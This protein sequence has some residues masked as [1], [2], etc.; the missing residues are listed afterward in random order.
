MKIFLLLSICLLFVFQSFAQR[1]AGTWQDYLSFANAQKVAIGNERV[2]CASLGGLFYYDLQDNSVYKVSQ[3]SD[4]GIKTIE[5]DPANNRLL[6]AY[7]NSNLDIISNGNVV[8]LSDIKRKMI[9]ADKSINDI[10]IRGD[11]AYLAC[12]FG[13][14]VVNLSKQEVKDTYFIGEDG[15]PL[16]VYD[17]EFYGSSIYA[18][19]ET[20]LLKAAEEGT[21]LLDYN[22]WTKVNDIP[23]ANARFS[24]LAVHQ[25]DLMANYA[26]GE[27]GSD[28]VFTFDG[29]SWN[30]YLTE[31]NSVI[32]MSSTQNYLSVTGSNKVLILDASHSV[33]GRIESYTLDDEYVAMNAKNAIIS[34][35]GTIWI[36]DNTNALIKLTG[37]NFE[38][39]YPA[40]PMDNEVFFLTS[41]NADVWVTPGGRTDSWNNSFQTPRFQRFR[42]GEWK[43]FSKTNIPEMTGFFDVVCLVVDPAD[44]NHFYVGSWG[45]GVLEFKN[46]EFVQRYTNHNSPL[47]SALPQQPDEPFV[48]IGGLDFDSQGNLWITNVSTSGNN[49]HKLSPAGEW[50][51]FSMSQVVGRDVGQVI[52]TE[53]DDKWVLVPRGFDAYVIDKNGTQIEKLLVTSYFTNGKDEV[54]T[55]MN[56]VYSIAEDNEGAIWIGTSKGVA[57]YHTPWRIWD[58]TGSF[59]ATQPGLDLNDGIYH[60]L[61]ATE[62]VTAIAV[63]GANRKWLGTKGSGVFL[64]S[65]NGEQEVEHFT[66]E[67]SP[68]LSNSISSITINQKSGEV[69]F[70]TDKGLISYQSEAS[71]GKKNYDEVYVYPNPVRE[72]YDGPVT[73]TNLIS[74]TD[75]KITDISGNLVYKTTSLGGQAVWDG[76]NLN[77]NRVKTGVYLVFCNDENGEETHIAKLLFIH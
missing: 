33:I 24:Q 18:A 2:Y 57:V 75:I 42:A 26:S 51:S 77:G 69:F 30:S 70:G 38:S 28:E 14:V 7:S 73:I 64:V 37:S 23:N 54:K 15:M 3:L 9:T 60:P 72:T 29:N 52:V 66:S 62:T 21:N 40:G 10:T 39:I 19:T 36:A 22:N 11:E 34:S 16:A 46:D 5:S 47:E 17:V 61:L 8:N 4:F 35:D 59:Y 50:E 49:L 53:N 74:N 31:V 32:D 63:D 20:G 68:L 55:R 48:R 43:N 1:E 12:G 65:E 27:A 45:G 58:A 13:I 44:D 25:G 67:N 6:I 76:K 71:G 56:D 41:N